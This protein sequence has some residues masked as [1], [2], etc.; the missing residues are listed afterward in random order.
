MGL[1]QKLGV[2]RS[3]FHFQV[4]AIIVP[5]LWGFGYNFVISRDFALAY[6]FFAASGVWAACWW[7]CSDHILKQEEL[8]RKSVRNKHP[9]VAAKRKT[10]LARSRTMGIAS[11]ILIAGIG[12]WF[13]HSKSVQAALAA[14][15]GLLVPA[16][17]P[18]PTNQ[19]QGEHTS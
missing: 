17:D 11:S 13:V 12:C 8:A 15:E 2:F 1:M 18:T 6:S 4:T 5:L 14:T 10:N 19:C 9:L 16:S 3:L 7:L